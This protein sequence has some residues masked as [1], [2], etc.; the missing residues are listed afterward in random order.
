MDPFGEGDA[1]H[2]LSSGMG[3]S[4]FEVQTQ[5][6]SFARDGLSVLVLEVPTGLKVTLLPYG[7]EEPLGFVTVK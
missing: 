3:P 6:A 7:Q 4:S 5:E 2:I 1:V